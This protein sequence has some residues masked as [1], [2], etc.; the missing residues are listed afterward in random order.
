MGALALGVN[1]VLHVSLQCLV[2]PNLD[3]LFEA[4]I[5]VRLQRDVNLLAHDQWLLG[6]FLFVGLQ[7]LFEHRNITFCVFV[8]Q[9]TES[10]LMFELLLLQLVLGVLL[11]SFNYHC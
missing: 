10:C 1:K 6:K 8:A 4:A 7:L 2:N 3:E 5:E 11:L 9:V